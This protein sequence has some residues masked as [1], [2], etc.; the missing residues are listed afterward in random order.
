MGMHL[1]H[2]DWYWSVSPR[3]Q[4][5]ASL[6]ET[7]KTHAV[8]TLQPQHKLFPLQIYS[9]GTEPIVDIDREDVSRL[10]TAWPLKRL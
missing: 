2:P 7:P 4:T 6:S 10:L 1:V 5:R 9:H 3:D 8:W